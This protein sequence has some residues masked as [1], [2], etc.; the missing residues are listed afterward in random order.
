MII[1]MTE[2]FQGLHDCRHQVITGDIY[3]A[4]SALMLFEID[5]PASP[6]QEGFRDYLLQCDKPTDTNFFWDSL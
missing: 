5:P 6:Y 1:N 2:Y 4:Q 3:C